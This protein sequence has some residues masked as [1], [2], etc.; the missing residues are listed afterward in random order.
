MLMPNFIIITKVYSKVSKHF[1][2][3]SENKLGIIC[4]FYYIYFIYF[5]FLLK[6]IFMQYILTEAPL[7]QLLLRGPSH[8]TCH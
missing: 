4:H 7:P 8:L 5:Y 6:I 2:A 1:R 3:P